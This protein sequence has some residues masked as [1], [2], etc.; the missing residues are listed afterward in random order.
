[1]IGKNLFGYFY[2]LALLLLFLLPVGCHPDDKPETPVAPKAYFDLL[3]ALDADL[4]LQTIA[5]QGNSTHLIFTD[6]STL[7]IPLE[8]LFIYDCTES[9]PAPVRVD[10]A[11]GTWK[12]GD[13]DTGITRSEEVLPRNCVPVY[14]W[15]TWASVSWIISNG[16]TLT[17]RGESATGQYRLPVVRITT[18]GGQVIADKINYVPGTIVFED[19]DGLY[20][21]VPL[22]ECRMGI[23]GRGNTTWGF[24]KK[25]WR[26][27]LDEKQSVMGFHKDKNYALLANYSDKT[28]LRNMV[29]ME[30][31]RILGF[32]WTPHMVSVEVFLNDEYQGCY[33]LSEHKQVASHKVD[34]K[35][36]D[37]ETVEGEAL[38]GGYYIEI[39]GS[40]DEPFCFW[41]DVGIPVML[42]EPEQPNDAQ[43][44]YLKQLFKDFEDALYSEDFKDPEKGYAHY[45][46]VD[47]FVKFF[48]L[49]E[50]AKNVDGNLRKSTFLT[51]EQGGKLEM[52]HVWDFDIA[53]GNCNYFPDFWPGTTNTYEGWFVKDYINYSYKCD[54][55]YGR[56]FKDPAFVEKVRAC[57]NQHKE[58]FLGIPDYIDENVRL[59]GKAPARNFERWK[60]LGKKVWP[61]VVAP[62]TYSGE[63]D[64]LKEFYLN[65]L[66]WMDQALAAL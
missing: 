27:K 25:P 47:S 59:L 58:E 62:G 18:D 66:N 56:L 50:L 60:I 43:K 24:E 22:Q 21:D 23:R 51:K 4:E 49:Q 1:M 41:T 65:R 36:V 42:S 30:L 34:I 26:V 48:I 3:D 20:S 31:S 37:P 29:A 28:L 15:F 63:I 64:Y 14:A 38:T 35:V 44:A 7:D 8:E 9:D 57:W 16:E 2:R 17:I 32:S 55:W 61:N 6:G 12:V 13:K 19:P 33:T 46:D 52:Y 54:G 11:T 39:D 40:Q 53:F 5:R 45:I 10:P